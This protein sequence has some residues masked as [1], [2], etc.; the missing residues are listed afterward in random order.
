MAVVLLS[1][2]DE[3]GAE[4]LEFTHEL[5]AV[6]HRNGLARRPGVPVVVRVL[7]TFRLHGFH[8]Q[9]TRCV[10]SV[11][12]DGRDGLRLAIDDGLLVT[13][14]L[15]NRPEECLSGLLALDESWTTVVERVSCCGEELHGERDGLLDG[16]DARI[17]QSLRLLCPY[18]LTGNEEPS[19]D[20]FLIG[21]C[22]HKSLFSL[23]VCQAAVSEESD[24]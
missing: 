13:S 8:R 21:Y 7:E 12:Q 11:V 24:K 15:V 4:L 20:G 6:C 16:V 2:D 10:E 23:W 14:G 18:G 19:D 1:A 9:R 17:V 5:D 22:A 3:R